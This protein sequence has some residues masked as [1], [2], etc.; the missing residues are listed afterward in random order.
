MLA[1]QDSQCAEFV[2][3]RTKPLR[4]SGLALGSISNDWTDA[5]IWLITII[6]G[7]SSPGEAVLRVGANNDFW[8]EFPYAH[9]ELA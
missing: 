5:L 8:A 3:A 7:S 1:T 4:R 2:Y 6:I 9:A